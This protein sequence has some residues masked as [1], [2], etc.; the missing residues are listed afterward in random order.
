M[1]PGR[2]HDISSSLFLQENCKP[3]RQIAPIRRS[4]CWRRALRKLELKFLEVDTRRDALT[5]RRS[6]L[7]SLCRG[8]TVTSSIS[9][10]KATSEG[11]S[12]EGKGNA[13]VDGVL[14]FRHGV[15]RV[16]KIRACTCPSSRLGREPHHGFS[17]D[18]CM[19]ALP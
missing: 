4:K 11:I 19:D 2:R 7:S 6:M 15:E 18:V 5:E 14:W 8:T 13:I 9:H 10:K 3:E 16:Q 12:P 1:Q 17:N